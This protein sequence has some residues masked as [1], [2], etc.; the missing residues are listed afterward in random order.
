MFPVVSVL[1][2]QDFLRILVFVTVPPLGLVWCIDRSRDGRARSHPDV[3]HDLLNLCTR[4]K[5]GISADLTKL[6]VSIR[7]FSHYPRMG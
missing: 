7:D 5:A 6:V 4:A 2:Q 3:C 1:L